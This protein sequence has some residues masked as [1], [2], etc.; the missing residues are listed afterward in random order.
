MT[1]LTQRRFK[2]EDADDDMADTSSGTVDNDSILSTPSYKK[3][4][5]KANMAQAQYRQADIAAAQAK[6]KAAELADE[7][8][9][10]KEHRW[11]AKNLS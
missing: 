8:E 6:A 9:R 5:G 2:D 1:D 4:V 10:Q 3:L 7:V 11:Q